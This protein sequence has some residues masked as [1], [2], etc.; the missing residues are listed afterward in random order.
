MMLSTRTLKTLTLVSLS[1]CSLSA[2]A[3]EKPLG[4]SGNGEAGY[5]STT[6]NTSNTSMYGAIKL[7]YNE[8]THEFK[9]LFEV[10]YKTEN[11]DQTQER[12]LMDLQRNHFYNAARDYY[13]F[14]NAQFENSRFENIDLDAS[15]SLGLGKKL[16]QTDRTV[17]TG[18][19]GIGYQSTSYSKAGGGE[20][21]DQAIG[22]LKLDLVHKLNDMVDFS[23][24]IIY[25]AGSDRTKIETNTGL[26]VKVADNMNV[27]AG[28]KFRHNDKPAANVKKT[29]TQTT[30]T[31]IYDF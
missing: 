6:G 9:S 26:K 14:I 2:Y 17:L 12:Y 25:L 20:T 19:A 5:N 13:S 7:N 15:L 27:K 21:E 16:Y 30:L 10:N 11:G 1:F 4:F 8:T 3:E 22:R 24:D 18:E 23:Q 28:Y 31:L 29:D